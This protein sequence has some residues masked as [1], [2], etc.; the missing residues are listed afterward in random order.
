MID[1][2]LKN[3]SIH[4]TIVLKLKQ[5]SKQKNATGRFCKDINSKLPYH[6]WFLV[7]VAKGLVPGGIEGIVN[8]SK[9]IVSKMAGD[10]VPVLLRSF[11]LK[12]F[13][14]ITTIQNEIDALM[15]EK[16]E[17]LTPEMVK[18]LLERVV[19]EHLGNS[20]FSES[21]F[22]ISSTGWLVVWGNVF[23][24]LIGVVSNA[25]GLGPS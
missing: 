21:Y 4:A 19:R 24:S 5:A 2:T 14:D 22:T 20:F 1:H 3:P 8:V 23:G 9:P 25:A 15:T 17:L 11:D 7:K 6:F 18:E 13:V 12:E 10:I 16:L